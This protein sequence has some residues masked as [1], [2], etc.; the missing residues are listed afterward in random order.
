LGGI[1][2]FKEDLANVVKTKLG[3][4]LGNTNLY[5][6]SYDPEFDRFPLPR[7]WRMPDLFKFSGDEDRTTWEHISH[8]TAQLGEAGVHN[9]LKVCLFSLS[10]T[11]TAFAWFSL[12]APGSIISWDMLEHKF[13]DH[14]YSGSIQLKLIDL[15]SVRQGRDETTSAYIKRFKETKNQCFNLS[16]TDMDLPDI[17][18]K[19]LRSS[20]RDKIEGFDFLSVAQVQVRALVVENRM[21]KDKDNFK[22]HRSNVHIIDYDSDSSNDS[23][24][25]VYATEFVWPSKKS[26][27]CSSLK[28]ASKGRQEEIKFTFDVSKC[29]RIFDE[30]LKYGNIKLTN[31]IPP[32]EELKRRAYCKFHNSFSHA[33]NDCNVFRRQVQSAINEGRLTFH[34]MQVDKA[35]F[36]IN[37]MDLQ[38]PKVLVRPHQ[39][40]ATKGKNMVIGEAKPD[41]RGKELILKVEYQKTPDG[42][43]TFK[44]TVSASGYGGQ[45]SSTPVDQRPS[46]P[47]LARPVRPVEVSGQT[48][49][50]PG[51][52]RMIKPSRLEIGNWKLNVSKN[53]GSGPKPKVTFDMLFDKYSKQKA[54]TSDRP[55]KKG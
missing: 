32:L 31:T 12:L 4:D 20:I 45:G 17:C 11:V 8:Y 25:E 52:P 26:Y 23:D 22:S 2:K 21:N 18:L 48:G 28:P 24:N 41:L 55:L 29:D 50:P 19:C 39:V 10:L 53:Q 5:Q 30:F 46:E 34:E 43:K 9:A 44:V 3:V 27:S 51:R 15:T 33:I 16:I 42:K 1:Y 47:S 54:V 14:F 13:H 38:Q 36:L 7:G 49:V 35:P 6:K 37:T 40:E